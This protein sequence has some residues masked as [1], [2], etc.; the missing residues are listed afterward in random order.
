M[1]QVAPTRPHTAIDSK[2]EILSYEPRHVL[3]TVEPTMQADI[4]P[5]RIVSDRLPAPVLIRQVRVQ[6]E[7][8]KL[9]TQIW[10]IVV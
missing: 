8:K 3:A 6:M 10:G 7:G 2:V 4:M 1:I 9:S 5:G